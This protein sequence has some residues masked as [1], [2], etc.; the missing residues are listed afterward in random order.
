MT[1]SGFLGTMQWMSF[2][3][4]SLY[5]W[6]LLGY[7]V[8]VVMV[9]L[10]VT[11]LT[12]GLGDDNGRGSPLKGVRFGGSHSFR[13]GVTRRGPRAWKKRTRRARVK[14]TTTSTRGADP[15]KE[16]IERMISC[17]KD[18]KIRQQLSAR[19]GRFARECNRSKKDRRRAER[20]VKQSTCKGFERC[21]SAP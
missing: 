18:P 6:G 7:G 12:I 2:K 15:C 9:A 11:P 17:K 10:L 5:E 1:E 16:A 20:C 21:L 8:V 4:T 19:K 14:A 3:P 13:G